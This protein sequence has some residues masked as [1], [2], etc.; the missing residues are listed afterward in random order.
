VFILFHSL[1]I[2]GLKVGSPLSKTLHFSV[3]SHSEEIA[4][5]IFKGLIEYFL[6]NEICFDHK[7]YWCIITAWPSSMSKLYRLSDRSLSAKLVPTL[8]ERGCPV[9]STTDPYCRISVFQTGAPQ[10]YT[11]G[12]MDPVLRKCGGAGHQTRTSRSVARSSDH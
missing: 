9:V 3:W 4:I 5:L 6:E 10:L 2:C 8:A 11:W 1:R 12:W 7:W